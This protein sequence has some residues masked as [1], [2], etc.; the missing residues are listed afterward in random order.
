MYVRG[1]SETCLQ[2]FW[3]FTA[4]SFEHLNRFLVYYALRKVIHLS[5]EN[6]T[7][8]GT[9][10]SQSKIISRGLF[11]KNLFERTWTIPHTTQSSQT[12]E[13]CMHYKKRFSVIN[14]KVYFYS[15]HEIQIWITFLN[16]IMYMGWPWQTS[17]YCYS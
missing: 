11:I 13:E 14:W 12:V 15:W 7:K 6:K 16:D 3:C 10:K 9:N 17:V 1:E 8:E 5:L 4:H 2:V